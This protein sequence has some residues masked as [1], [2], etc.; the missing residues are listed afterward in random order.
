MCHSCCFNVLVIRGARWHAGSWKIGF[1]HPRVEDFFGFLI[2][3]RAQGREA[4]QELELC[5]FVLVGAAHCTYIY[6]SLI[7]IPGCFKT[8]HVV[9]EDGIS[10]QKNYQ[11]QGTH[12]HV[13]CIYEAFKRFFLLLKPLF[14]INVQ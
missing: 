4:R 1:W 2:L 14:A 8:T 3:G 5:S 7:L 6:I 12:A 11:A 9:S 10:W 13:Y